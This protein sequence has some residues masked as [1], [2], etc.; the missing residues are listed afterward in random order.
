MQD[1][2]EGTCQKYKCS[3]LYFLMCAVEE[4]DKSRC[5]SYFSTVP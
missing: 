5:V 1:I 4:I 3:G 2:L